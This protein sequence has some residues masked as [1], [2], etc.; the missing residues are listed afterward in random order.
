MVLD[1][2]RSAK[3]NPKEHDIDAIMASYKRFSAQDSP[4][5]DERTKRLLSGHG[6]IEALIAIR[7]AGERAPGGIIVKDGVWMVPIQ[8]GGRT[9]NNKEA[10]DYLIT[11]NR[12]TE[13]GGWDDEVLAEMLHE[14]EDFTGTGW[15]PEDEEFIELLTEQGHFD[16]LKGA[17]DPEPPTPEH[18]DDD[19]LPRGKR[20]SFKEGQKRKVGRHT[21]VCARCEDYMRTMQDNSID[22]IVCDPPYLINFM[23]KDWDSA[24]DGNEMQAWHLKWAKEALRILKPGGHIVAF[25]ATR[26]IHRLAV[27]IEDAGFELRDQF[28]WAYATGFPK[29][30]DISKAIDQRSGSSR[31]VISS[32]KDRRND[33]T[34]YGLGHSGLIVS[35]KPITPDAKLWDGFGTALKPSYEP[36]VVAM[37][38]LT[39]TFAENVLEH[40]TGA[41][42]IDA[43]RIEPGDPSWF[44]PGEVHPGYPNGPGGSS[45]PKNGWGK[46]QSKDVRPNEWSMDKGRWPANIYIC[47]KPPQSEKNAGLE[48]YYELSGGEATNRKEGSKGLGNPRAGAGRNGGAKAFHPTIKPIRLFRQLVR[49]VGCQPGSVI[50][51]PFLGSGTTMVSAEREGFTCI[52]IEQDGEYAALAEARVKH[53]VKTQSR[54]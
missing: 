24:K 48:E 7:D 26:T 8:R 15:D 5:L 40:G 44:G 45:D 47:P 53:A 33:G 37:K 34:T 14:M 54:E 49:L 21:I 46:A 39:G 11:A 23:N 38:P 13:V 32:K 12:L 35:D 28:A 29:S 43:C 27:A 30:L 50:L 17:E 4:V 9:K 1:E 36:A 25:A 22:A 52:G 31:A 3:R 16:P 20:K 51:D 2:V 18:R 10:R 6:R 42:N 41:I 19:I